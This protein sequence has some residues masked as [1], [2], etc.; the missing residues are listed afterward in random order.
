MRHAW[1]VSLI[2]QL[3]RRIW[4]SG[5]EKVRFS[6]LSKQM[7]SVLMIPKPQAHLLREEG[8]SSIFAI[9]R[10]SI[11]YDKTNF[12]ATAPAVLFLPRCAQGKREPER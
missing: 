9:I 4:P 3:K 5:Q 2:C 7:S 10:R 11:V 1:G 12:S 8:D 6:C